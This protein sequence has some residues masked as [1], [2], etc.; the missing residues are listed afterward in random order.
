M[1]INMNKIKDSKILVIGGTGFIGS[2]VVDEL[3]K[4]DV[5]EIVVY[6]NF[7][8]G[9]IDNLRNALRDPRVKV[10]E[11]GGISARQIFSILQ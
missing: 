9:T 8:R 1:R 11:V 4:E 5:K 7:C 2:H 3:T 10:Y 6:D